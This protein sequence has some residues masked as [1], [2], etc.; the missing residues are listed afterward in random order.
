MDK[1][2]LTNLSILNKMALTL[3]KLIQPTLKIGLRG[4]R[5]LFGWDL[6]NQLTNMLKLLDEEAIADAL[7]S[8]LAKS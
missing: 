3:L 4:I 2:A 7:T 6:I 1:N 8:R 5:K